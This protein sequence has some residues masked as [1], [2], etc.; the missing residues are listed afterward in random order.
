MEYGQRVRGTE[1]GISIDAFGI[2]DS[3]SYHFTGQGLASPRSE[4]NVLKLVKQFE[5]LTPGQIP[6]NQGFCIEN[7]LVR[8]PLTAGDNESVTMFASLTGH[9][10]VAI[11][12]DTSINTKRLDDSLLSRDAQSET[13]RQFAANFKSLRKGPRTINAIPGEEVL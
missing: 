9:P 13:K 7:G 6:T 12:L 4:G 1:E 5:A 2:K 11:R 10:D 3:V 8:E